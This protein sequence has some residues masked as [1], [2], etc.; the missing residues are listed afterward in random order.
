LEFRSGTEY[1][2]TALGLH[3]LRSLAIRLE[4]W[5]P[6]Y[7]ISEQNI[8]V[9]TYEENRNLNKLWPTA[10]FVRNKY[11]LLLKKFFQLLIFFVFFKPIDY[12]YVSAACMC[13]M[14]TTLDIHVG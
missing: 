7:F 14:D 6:R 2:G 10:T 9:V 11:F 4:T 5:T 12:I 13:D 3:A 8:F 1:A